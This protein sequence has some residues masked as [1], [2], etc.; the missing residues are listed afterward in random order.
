MK[1]SYLKA[2]IIVSPWL[3]SKCTSSDHDSQ[4]T[5]PN[6]LFAMGDDISFPHMS[7]YGTSWVRT[8][9]FDRVAQDG[10]LFNN[11]YTPNCD[12]S[13]TKTLILNM[14]RN[15]VSANT[16]NLISEAEMGRN[17]IRSPKILNA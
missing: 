9:G 15:R 2:L 1:P 3:F 13:P 7:A 17:Y 8:P 5:R 11:A 10:I 14:N 4:K 12:G 16:G 6:I